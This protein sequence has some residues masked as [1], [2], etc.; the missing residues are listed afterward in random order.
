VFDQ[1]IW[2]FFG[3]YDIMYYVEWQMITSN[4]N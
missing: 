1:V 2:I 3:S 4:M